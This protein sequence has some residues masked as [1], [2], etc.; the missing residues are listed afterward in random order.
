M[1]TS[2]VALTIDQDV[3]AKA[4]RCVKATRLRSLSAFVTAAVDEKLRRD[5]LSEILDEMDAK[6]GPPD[7]T[8]MAWARRVFQRSS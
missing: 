7:A 5:V 8:A 3:L 1:A 4:R 2:K 6:L